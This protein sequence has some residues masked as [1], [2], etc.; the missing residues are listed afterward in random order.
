MFAQKWGSMHN[1]VGCI[2]GSPRNATV[3]SFPDLGMIEAFPE[4]PFCELRVHFNLGTS[5]RWVRGDSGRLQEL[6]ELAFDSV[7]ARANPRG[8]RATTA[9]GE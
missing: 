8:P 6:G 3:C 7:P 2:A 1:P 9:A 5:Q 4:A